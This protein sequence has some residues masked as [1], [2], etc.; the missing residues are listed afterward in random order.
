[1]QFKNIVTKKEYEVNGEKKVK[2]LQAGTL[3]INNDGKMFVEMNHQPDTTYFV[4]D[5]K[6]KSNESSL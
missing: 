2:W 4:F 3:R 6:D 5:Q 1:M